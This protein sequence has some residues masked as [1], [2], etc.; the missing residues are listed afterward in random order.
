M[1]TRKYDPCTPCVVKVA[2]RDNTGKVV[3][4]DVAKRGM[5]KMEAISLDLMKEYIRAGTDS[6]VAAPAAVRAANSLIEALNAERDE[7]IGTLRRSLASVSRSL[8][9]VMNDPEHRT[10]PEDTDRLMEA[11][12]ILTVIR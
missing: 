1:K 3:E 10:L 6:A 7:D 8:S 12:N 11:Q 5:T 4:R 2:E 9:R